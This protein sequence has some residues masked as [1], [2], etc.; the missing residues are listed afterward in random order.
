[1]IQIQ[2]LPFSNS[3]YYMIPG[4]AKLLNGR[5]KAGMFGLH[6]TT[7]TVKLSSLSTQLLQGKKKSVWVEYIWETKAFS[8]TCQISPACDLLSRSSAKESRSYLSQKP[9]C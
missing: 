6:L 7:G 5:P 8:L 9:T 2:D 4:S 3:S 1:M